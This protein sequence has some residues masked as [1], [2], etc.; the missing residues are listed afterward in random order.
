MVRLMEHIFISLSFKLQSTSK[1]NLRNNYT[2]KN[3]VTFLSVTLY[4]HI[5]PDFLEKVGETFV[6]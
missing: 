5:H 3:K 6:L 2:L 4:M 1:W